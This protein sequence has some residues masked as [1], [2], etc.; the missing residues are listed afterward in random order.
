MKKDLSLMSV[1][2]LNEQKKKLTNIY[3]VLG[4]FMIVTAI[5]LVYFAISTKNYAFIAV[6]LG[7]CITFLPGLA[8]LAEVNKE[9]KKRNQ[10]Q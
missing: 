7:S 9:I 10:A 8:S 1:T 5:A 3:V 2:E 4:I 6:A